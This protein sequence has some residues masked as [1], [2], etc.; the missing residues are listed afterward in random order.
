MKPD[1]CETLQIGFTQHANTVGIITTLKMTLKKQIKIE[2][3]KDM[4]NAEI[5]VWLFF[6]KDFQFQWCFSMLEPFSV[7]FSVSYTHG[8]STSIIHFNA[9][10]VHGHD[11]QI[12]WYLNTIFR[13]K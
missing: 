7:S 3:T 2:I 9:T 1:T 4:G 5:S 12:H 11:F 13:I 10:R 8:V 6:C